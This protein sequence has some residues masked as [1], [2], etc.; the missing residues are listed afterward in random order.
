[1]SALDS[2]S[3]IPV[4]TVKFRSANG[5]VREGNFLIDSGAGTTVIRKGFAGDL[6]LQGQQER[7]DIAVVGGER[8]SQTNSRRMKFWISPL[9]GKETFPIHPGSYNYKRTQPQPHLVKVIRSPE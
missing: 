8:I 1:M 3:I 4:V 5:R 6:G 7:I 2:D 9:N